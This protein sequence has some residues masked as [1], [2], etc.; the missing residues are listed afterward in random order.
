MR[1][2]GLIFHRPSSRH[3]NNVLGR[4]RRR[5]GSIGSVAEHAVML[6]SPCHCNV[7]TR[8]MMSWSSLAIFISTTKPCL[9]CLRIST[10]LLKQTMQSN[11][12]KHYH[13]RFDSII[14]LIPGR[15]ILFKKKLPLTLSI[16]RTV[17]VKRLR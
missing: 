9:P 12:S 1:D 14:H 6:S 8:R 13:I 7:S 17:L 10:R 5:R 2:H 4:K 15:N 11:V 16:S 3:F